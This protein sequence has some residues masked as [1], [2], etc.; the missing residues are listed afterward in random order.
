[1]TKKGGIKIDDMKK[2]HSSSGIVFSKV[3]LNMD[4]VLSFISDLNPVDKLSKE[5][6][7]AA[8]KPNPKPV[9]SEPK[10]P[11]QVDDKAQLENNNKEFYPIEGS[12]PSESQ[13]DASQPQKTKEELI[14][15]VEV[16]DSCAKARRTA[17]ITA[18][19][20]VHCLYD[21]SYK[22]FWFTHRLYSPRELTSLNNYG[23]F[24]PQYSDRAIQIQKSE[25]GK[26]FSYDTY[27]K[28]EK[29]FLF[30]QVVLENK[31]DLQNQ[32]IEIAGDELTYQYRDIQEFLEALRQN[33]EDIKEVISTIKY[34]E[35]HKND[36]KTP[37][38][39]GQVTSSL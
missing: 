34:L 32:T 29:G 17:G 20:R 14:D 23:R 38:E 8:S 2:K 37:Q 33:A 11:N 27:S 5:D 19:A 1:M 26:P 35:E 39:R 13:P 16:L 31:S 7:I 15:I 6:R 25:L 9:A 3:Q 18:S 12:I 4:A 10:K 21:G 22:T 24:V 28:I 30:H 36:K